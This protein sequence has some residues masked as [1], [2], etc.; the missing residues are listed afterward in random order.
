MASP[1]TYDEK[2]VLVSEK[3]N[4]WRLDKFLA[5]LDFISSRSRASWLI[6]QGLVTK[7]KQTLKPSSKVLTGDELL[8]RVPTQKS[9]QLI[10]YNIPLDILYEDDVCA[11]INKPAGLVVHPAAG[12]SQDTLVN[13][14]LYHIKDLSMGFH[15]QRP[16]IVHRLDKDTSG[17]L[18]IAKNDFAHEHLAKQFKAKTVHRIYWALVYG[19]PKPP[20]GTIRSHLARHPTLRKKFSS[21][22]SSARGK[23]A[24]THYSTLQHHKGVSWLKCQLET[25]RTHQI[26]VH[27]SEMQHPILAD[28]IY[29]SDRWNKTLSTE[30]RSAITKLD[31]IGLHACELGFVHPESQKM[32][33]F[34]V[35]WPEDLN[36]LVTLLGLKNVSTP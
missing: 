13:A 6:A 33:H 18:V 29:G 10:P 15:E 14:L 11:V 26:R 16:G 7:N 28:P 25:G 8:V 24:I 31:R 34:S 23:I 12:H 22:S 35:G 36:A 4:N 3:F 2:N 32:M 27:L 5:E 9:T 19:I 21:Q 1:L 20:A 30:L 17:I